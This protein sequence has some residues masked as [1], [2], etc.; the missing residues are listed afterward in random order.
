M[1]GHEASRPREPDAGSEW[2]TAFAEA[3]F[4]FVDLEMS[5]LNVAKDRVIEV[6]IKKVR[7]GA[8]ISSFTSLVKPDAVVIGNSHIHGIQASEL[9]NAPLFAT[10]ADRILEELSGSIFV[11]HGAIWDVRFLEMEFARAGKPYKVEHYLDTLNLSRRSFMLDSHALEAL[12][13]HF[14]IVRAREHRAEDDVDALITVFTRCIEQLKPSTPR[15]LWEVRVGDRMARE[16]VLEA[17]RD[18]LARKV[19]VKVSYRPSRKPAIAF[20]LMVTAIQETPPRIVGFELPG[21]GRKELRA[22][23]IL[24]ATVEDG[25][26]A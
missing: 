7:G 15:D 20:T 4:A 24:S 25:E 17:C 23:R 9:E 18:A 21:R 22:E 16:G 3:T 8:V 1:S 19:P 12:C 10:L 11:A 6:C 26:R 5:G 2:D 14:G 13:K